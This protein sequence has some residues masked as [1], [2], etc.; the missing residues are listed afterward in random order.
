[1]FD[2]CG[3]EIGDERESLGM[4]V[5][6]DGI[7]FPAAHQ[8]DDIGVNVATQEGHGP[9]GAEGARRYVARF[10][11]QRRQRSG[12]E[13]KE[14]REVCVGKEATVVVDVVGTEFRVVGG[15]VGAEVLDTATKGA[16]GTGPGMTAA[17]VAKAKKPKPAN[18]EGW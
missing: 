4:E 16:Y 3:G 9:A 5:T 18:T 12:G 8:L 6:E 7:G 10:V 1:M 15:V 13:R 14:T 2:H 11:V 17:S